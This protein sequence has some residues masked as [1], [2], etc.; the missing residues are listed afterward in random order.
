MRILIVEDDAIIAMGLAEGLREEGLEV[1]GPVHSV[2]DA[3]QALAADT[4]DAAVLDVRLK[5][6]GGSD[7][8]ASLR[9]QGVPFIWLTGL[10]PE[11]FDTFGAPVLHKPTPLEDL[12]N[13]LRAL[14]VRLPADNRPG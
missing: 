9:A 11:N 13:A 14:P 1:V 6:G 8:A 4:P 12:A 3:L 10:L 2:A 7:I 5:R